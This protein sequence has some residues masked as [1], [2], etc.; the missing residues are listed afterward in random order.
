MKT[1]ISIE[2]N[3]EYLGDD[4]TEDQAL[5]WAECAKREVIDYINTYYPNTEFEIRFVPETLSINNQSYG[6]ALIIEDV[7][8]FIIANWNKWL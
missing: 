7:D 3:V 8:C 4:I 5:C 1:V 2:T 6:D